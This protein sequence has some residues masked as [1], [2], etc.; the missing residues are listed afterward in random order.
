MKLII[1]LGNPG[2]KYQY[3]RHNIGFITINSLAQKYNLQWK[4]QN[5][6]KAK[7]CQTFFE[8]EKIILAKPQT[9][10]NLSGQA[11]NL[12]KTYYKLENKDILIIQDDLDLELGEFFFT[13]QSGHGGHNGIK[14]IFEEIKSTKINRL[15]IGINR[16]QNNKFNIKDWVL[17]NFNKDEL[18]QITEIQPLLSDAIIDWSTKG[19]EYTMNNW[20]QYKKKSL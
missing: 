15:R 8:E 16:P 3:T 10:M 5:K 1:G 14:S 18:N 19:I 20:N 17:S 2:E 4:K 12:L 13:P 7:I 11:V 9:Y 6:Q